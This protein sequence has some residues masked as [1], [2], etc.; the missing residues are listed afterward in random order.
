MRALLQRVSSA[1]LTANGEDRGSIGPGLVVLLGVTH[2]DTPG[3][4]SDL[5]GRTVHLRIFEDENGRMNRSLLDCGG[6]LLLVPQF[7]L[8]AACRQGRRPSFQAA[9]TPALAGPLFDEFVHCCTEATSARV[10]TGIFGANMQVE[11]IND[12]PVTILLD[13]ADRSG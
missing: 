9:A 3:T 10:R 13:S 4:A 12:G 1:A 7:T 11:L 6:E 2:A 5:A 8:Y